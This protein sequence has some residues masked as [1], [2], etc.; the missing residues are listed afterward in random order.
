MDIE[1]IRIKIAAKQELINIEK[2]QNR[3]NELMLD[4]RVLQMR[5][6]ME[7]THD[8]IKKLINKD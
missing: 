8:G 5:L 1:V 3:K 7:T 2:D 6:D 4:L